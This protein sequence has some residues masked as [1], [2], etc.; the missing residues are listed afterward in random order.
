[1]TLFKELEFAANHG[2]AR[3][4]KQIKALGYKAISYQRKQVFTN[5]CCI[6]CCPF[7]MVVLSAGL[8]IFINSLIQKSVVVE[9]WLLFSIHRMQSHET[10]TSRN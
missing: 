2:Q 7:F 8:G 1:L 6:S 9:G 4:S 3:K 10:K 5:V